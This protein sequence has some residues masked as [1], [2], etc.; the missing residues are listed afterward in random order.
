LEIYASKIG[1][2][3]RRKQEKLADLTEVLEKFGNGM[4]AALEW[5]RRY[6]YKKVGRERW[7]KRRQILEYEV[8]KQELKKHLQYLR[9]KAIERKEPLSNAQLGI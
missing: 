4:L 2:V 3:S 9:N 7:I 5:I 8:A 1:F 6:Q